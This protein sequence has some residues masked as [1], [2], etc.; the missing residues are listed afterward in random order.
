MGGVYPSCRG[1]PI[2]TP[3]SEQNAE[4]NLMNS[5]PVIR[6][7][8]RIRASI[9]FSAI[10]FLIAV[11][12]AVSETPDCGIG[13][14]E[15]REQLTELS[16][17]VLQRVEDLEFVI[18]LAIQTAWDANQGNDVLSDAVDNAKDQIYSEV[19]FL[20][21][22]S[23]IWDKDKASDISEQMT[24]DTFGHT[25]VRDRISSIAKQ[26]YQE[27]TAVIETIVAE[28]SEETMKC[29]QSMID[30]E[31]PKTLS[32]E[33][34]FKLDG[35]TATDSAISTPSV[36]TATPI[37]VAG[38]VADTIIEDLLE[39]LINYADVR[40]PSS[41]LKKVLLHFELAFLE[42]DLKD[43]VQGVVPA[44]ES[45]LKRDAPRQIRE[46]IGD[47][48]RLALENEL[49]MIATDV[50][51]DRYSIFVDFMNKWNDT[52]V[53]SDGSKTLHDFL[54]EGKRDLAMVDELVNV[55]L[56]M[57]PGI[58]AEIIESG[59]FERL[60][61]LLQTQDSERSVVEKE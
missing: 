59:L 53:L 56:M 43:T 22:L 24:L 42:F 9:V 12:D 36:R 3:M 48:I 16:T 60:Y 19:G 58:T 5:P 32:D 54:D 14:S 15:I 33:L 47:E 46:S 39:R 10:S 38:I 52:I 23:T 51:E 8:S 49:P 28:V 41:V 61:H 2:G 27:F 34:L 13:K 50:A 45:R 55:L 18:D 4:S 30:D 11:P 21:R 44:I 1:C 26:A 17:I 31:L 7:P 40:I 35:P 25:P 57:T 20:D 6:R 29:Y 37:T